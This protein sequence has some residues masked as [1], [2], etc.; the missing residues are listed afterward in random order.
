MISHLAIIP[1]GNRRW[2]K[3]RGLPYYEGHLKGFERMKELIEKVREKGIKVLSVWAFSAENWNRTKEEVN[4]LMNIY[5]K[6]IAEDLKKALKEK[7]RI[8]HIGRKDRISQSLRKKIEDSEKQTEKFSKFYLV[9]ALDY[10][11]R[12]EVLRAISKAK[13][14]TTE[15]EFGKFLDTKN[16]P[17]PNPDLVIRT[18]GEVRTSGFMIWQT[19][20]SEWIFYPKYLPEFTARDLD[21]CLQSYAKRQRRFGK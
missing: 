10:G 5:E 21:K 8:I 6:W 15:E 12:D 2:A 4:Y 18:S 14:I 20:Y 19:A 7:I 1:D 17:Y 13:K 9:I 16:V 11:G 3:K